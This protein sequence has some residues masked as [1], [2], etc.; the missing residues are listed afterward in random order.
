MKVLK[1][2]ALLSLALTFGISLSAEDLT[3]LGGELTSDVFIDRNAI[4]L[5]APIVPNGSERYLLQLEGF[6]PFHRIFNKDEG[7]GPVFNHKACSACHINN[8]RGRDRISKSLRGGSP[9]L[10]KVAKKNVLNE[11]GSPVDFPGVGEQIR[12]HAL[13][14]RNAFDYDINLAY[15]DKV[16]RYPDGRRVNLRRPQLTFKLPGRNGRIFT[17]RKSAFSLRMTPP[18]IGPGLLEAI[19]EEDILALSD[20]DD[21]DSD[22]ISGKPQYVIDRASNTVKL[23]RFG[24]RASHTTVEEQTAAAAFFDMGLSNSLF[25]DGEEEYDL[26]DDSIHKMAVYLAIAGVPRALNQTDQSVINGQE[27]FRNINCSGCHTMTQTTGEL[28]EYPEVN[29][30]EIHP[31]T[32]ML[33]HDMGPELADKR[34]EFEATGREWR[35]T[36]LWGIGKIRNIAEVT[37]G[38]F[39]RFL[40]DGRARTI[41]EAILWHG[42]EAQASK[43]AFMNLTKEQR[44]ELIAFLRSL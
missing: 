12:N 25:N 10:I 22:G 40:H 4:Q 6:V 29:N 35:T 7:L 18:I 26:D 15:K 28:D 11:D 16:V 30:Q 37:N 31:F 13:I 41:E 36:P 5:P 17:Q 14:A 27:H 32:D 42:G 19:P 2:S 20:P 39:D 43:E 8:G 23:G 38:N 24:F 33:L 21:L 44:D 34:A 9:M 3:N 1:F